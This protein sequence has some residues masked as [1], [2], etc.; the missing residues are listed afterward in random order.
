MVPM[1]IKYGTKLA[2]PK[3]VAPKQGPKRPHFMDGQTAPQGS[4]FGATYFFWVNQKYLSILFT[5]STL[6][7]VHS[8]K[9]LAHSRP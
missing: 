2:P 3:K 4:R 9:E 5:S 7:V 1:Y 8:S 6:Q